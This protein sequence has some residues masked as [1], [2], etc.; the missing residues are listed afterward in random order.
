[1]PVNMDKLEHEIRRGE[2]AKRLL[3]DELVREAREHIE[4]ELWRLFK[5]TPPQDVKTLE[6]VK[7]MQYMH[8]KY[9]AY[10]GRAVTDGKLAQINLE[11]KK[12]TLRERM[13]G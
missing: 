6:F 7:G 1:M 13:F 5:E 9:F 12:K 8:A 4:S 2:Q 3:E 10:F 11:A